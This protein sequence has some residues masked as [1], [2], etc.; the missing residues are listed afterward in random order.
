MANINQFGPPYLV[1]RTRDSNPD[2]GASWNLIYAGTAV[3]LAAIASYWEAQ[4]AEDGTPLGFGYKTKYIYT[5]SSKLL[6]V[7]VPDEILYTTRWD[8]ESCVRPVSIWWLPG[9][10]AFLPNYAD[11]DLT[12]QTDLRLWMA[13]IGYLKAG[14]AALGRGQLPETTGGVFTDQDYE[15]MYNILRDGEMR[16]WKVSSLLRR[17][18]IPVGLWEARVRLV[19]RLQLYSLD[20][21]YNL[22][23]L[24]NDAYDR[25]VTVYDNLPPADPHTMWAWRLGPDR[26]G[27]VTGSGKVE[28]VREWQF[29]RWDTINNTFVE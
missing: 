26:S 17:R 6:H 11:F 14:V 4:N 1:S 23:G 2:T 28:E 8:V 16:E 20:G 15:L 27:G 5:G 29:A 7:V 25:A 24:T 10:R 13:R 22:F 3:E 19:G 21:I 18:T 9:T 12:D